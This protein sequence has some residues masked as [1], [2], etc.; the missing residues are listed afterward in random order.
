MFLTYFLCIKSPLILD[1]IIHTKPAIIRPPIVPCDVTDAIAIR[2]IKGQ[3]SAL[4]GKFGVVEINFK[5]SV[6]S[7]GDAIHGGICKKHN[8]FY[9]FFICK[10]KK[11]YQLQQ[12]IL[13]SSY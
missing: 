7:A 9:T 5:E 2:L 12:C 1:N 13:N 11:Y 8:Y 6:L 10:V 3:S 4:D